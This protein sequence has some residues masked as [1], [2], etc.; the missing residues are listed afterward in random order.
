[1]SL[2]GVSVHQDRDAG[3]RERNAGIVLEYRTGNH[4]FLAG[5]YRNSFNRDS[6]MLGYR[7]TFARVGKCGA[8][9]TI[10]V[11]NNYPLNDGGVVPYAAPSV[12]CDMGPVNITLFMIPPISE[13]IG[14]GLIGLTASLKVW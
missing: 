2:G 1:M 13:E 7:Y 10:G 5:Q 4:G 14:G 8:S 12:F 9:G 6:K 3:Y 11:V